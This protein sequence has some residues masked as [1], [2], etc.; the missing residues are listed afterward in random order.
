MTPIVMKAQYAMMNGDDFINNPRHPRFQEGGQIID[1]KKA[2]E[3]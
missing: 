3:N 2:N 1:L